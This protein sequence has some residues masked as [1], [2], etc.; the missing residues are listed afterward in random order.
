MAITNNSILILAGG[1]ATR[2]RPVTEKIPKAML[3]IAGKPFIY[4]QL[5]LL[6]ENGISNVIICA[7]YLGQQIEEYVKDGSSFGLRVQYSFD[8]EKLLGTGGAIKKAESLLDNEFGIVYGDSYL[9]IDYESVFEYFRNYSKTGIMTIFKNENKWDT[10][11]V[12]YRHGDI[13]KYD[14][15]KKTND[16][17]YIDYGFGILRKECFHSLPK[18]KV[19]D[20]ADIYMNLIEYKELL[21]YEIKK[22]FYEIGSFKG[23]EETD[24]Y[25][26][27]KYNIRV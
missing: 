3:E 26:R 7:G 15:K 8:G 21:G 22:R 23:L 10:S 5:R 12:V 14:K 27:D 25:I 20:L 17:E 6:K 11:N 24:N 4:W 2:L 16:M 13:I 18:N 1:L 19:I 9:D